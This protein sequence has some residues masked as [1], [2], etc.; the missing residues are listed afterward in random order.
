MLDHF[1][2][3]VVHGNLTSSGVILKDTDSW[4]SIWTNITEIS[5]NGAQDSTFYKFHSYSYESL[6]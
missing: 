2:Q 4:M 5:E 6:I 3:N 1:S